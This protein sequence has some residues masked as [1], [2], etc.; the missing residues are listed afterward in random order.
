[1]E[2]APRH[3]M[4]AAAN[5]HVGDSTAGH[6]MNQTDDNSYLLII[7]TVYMEEVMTYESVRYG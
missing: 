5:F 2:A 1:M 4:G 6:C 3:Q 7:Y